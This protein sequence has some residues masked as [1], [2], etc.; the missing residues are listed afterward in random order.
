MKT[1]TIVNLSL[2]A[3]ATGGLAFATVH[4]LEGKGNHAATAP[5]I[6]LD[7]QRSHLRW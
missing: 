4:A 7:S 3:I 1:K 2:L 5:N 6:T